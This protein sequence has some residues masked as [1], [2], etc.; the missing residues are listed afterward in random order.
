MSNNKILPFDYL[1][2]DD[3]TSNLKKVTDCKDFQELGE[4]LD[5]PK[6]TFSTW[7][8]HNRTSHEL[9]VRLSLSLGIPLEDLALPITERHKNKM[10]AEKSEERGFFRVTLPQQD[11][12]NID[13]YLLNNGSLIENGLVPYPTHRLNG[14]GLNPENVMELESEGA[15]YFIDKS[16]CDAVAGNYLISVDDRLSI[17]HIQRLPRKRLAIA[18]GGTTMEVPEQDIKVLGRV[19]ITL[20]RA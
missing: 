16:N 12:K 20:S 18:F 5:V 3:F 13:S 4:L 1:K 14:F 8:T 10:V 7:N 2:G 15:I 6:S 9:M 19:A 11:V 17:N